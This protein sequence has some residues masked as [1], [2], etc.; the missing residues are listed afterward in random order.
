MEYTGHVLAVNSLI[1]V[2]TIVPL[3]LQV[4]LGFRTLSHPFFYP[5]AKSFRSHLAYCNCFWYCM[6]GGIDVRVKRFCVSDINM[7]DL[8]LSPHHTCPPDMAGTR[9]SV[10]PTFYQ[11]TFDVASF[12]V[13][14]TKSYL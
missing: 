10:P 1:D 3:L 7:D 11:T 12:C 2:Y 9:L 6:A 13:F 14:F 8:F 4:R 5:A